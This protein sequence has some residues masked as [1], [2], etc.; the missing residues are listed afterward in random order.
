MIGKLCGI[1][2]LV[3]VGSEATLSACARV[4]TAV[5]SSVGA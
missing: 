3:L 2:G 1:R 5:K 4:Q